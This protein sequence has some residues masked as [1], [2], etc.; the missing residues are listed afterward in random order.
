MTYLINVKILNMYSVHSCINLLIASRCLLIINEIG[1]VHS[2]GNGLIRLKVI[3][4]RETY[5]WDY[6]FDWLK[7]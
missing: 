5:Q 6:Y 4:G 2:F 1:C 3:P 7:G